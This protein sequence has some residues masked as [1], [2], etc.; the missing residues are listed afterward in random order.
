MWVLN[1]LDDLESD[2]SAIHGVADMYS[3]PSRKFF[4]FA[5]RL[6]AYQG[7]LAILAEQEREES[8]VH[9]GMTQ[10]QAQAPDTSVNVVP[11]DA[12]TLRATFGEF[13]DVAEV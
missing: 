9:G 10:A 2:F 6:T 1:Y 7:V 5:Y 13:M 12:A 3:L 11:S 8:K 4:A